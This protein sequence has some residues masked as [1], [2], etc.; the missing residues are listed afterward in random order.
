MH[1]ADHNDPWVKDELHEF[2]K[3]ITTERKGKIIHNDDGTVTFKPH[4]KEKRLNK[5]TGEYE[6]IFSRQNVI[7]KLPGTAWK[8]RE[9]NID[10]P[11]NRYATREYSDRYYEISEELTERLKRAANPIDIIKA[12]PDWYNGVIYC[13]Q[14]AR[15]KREMF[16]R[17]NQNGQ[18]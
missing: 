17:R 14:N 2:Y 18:N 11:P 10:M 1:Y 7:T 5:T 16:R 13:L 3:M 12:Y 8:Y 4:V 15:I 9:A 6:E